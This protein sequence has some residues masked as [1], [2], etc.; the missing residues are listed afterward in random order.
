MFAAQVQA[1]VPANGRSWELATF[2]PPSSS[3]VLGPRPMDGDG[4]RFVYSVIGPHPG[5]SA[6]GVLSFGT[7]DRSPAGWV[8]APLG[9]PYQIE[10]TAVLDLV[11]PIM[12]IAFSDD[13]QASL[14]FSTVPLGPGAPPEGPTTLYRDTAAGS[15]EFI[16]PVGS[17]PPS[18]IYRGFADIAGDGSRV[19][20]ST[21]EH[22]LA[23]DA[24]RTTGNSVYA[25]DGD[26]L[27]LVDVD[28]GGALLST[29][30][31]EVSQANGMSNQGSGVFFTAPASCNGVE[32]V[33]L[34]DLDSETTVQIS[35][36]ECTR[37]DCDATADVAFAGATEDGEFAFL[38]TTQQL[39]DADHDAGR[40]LYRYDVATGKLNL[41][42][43]AP[44]EVS[45]EVVEGALVF[46]S[47]DGGR[48]YFRA[49]GEVI[50]GE[51]TA[52]E[53][54][55]MADGGGVHLVAPASFPIEAEIQLSADG[56]RALFVTK[57]QLLGAD[58]DSS[59]DAYLYDADSETLVRIS[60]GPAGGN[61]ASP[62]SIEAPTPLNRHEYEYGDL[63]QYYAITASGDRAF[64]M[65]D[66][67]LVPEDTNGV[68]D[69][70]EWWN[71]QASLVTPGGQPLKS[72]FGGISRD[73]R[74]LMFATNASLVPAD[75]DG[76]GRDIYLARLDGGFPR[77]AGSLPCDASSC[78]LPV[79]GRITRP[80][81][82]SMAPAR[83]KPGQLRVVEVASKAK[84]GAIAVVVSAP[85]PGSVSGLIWAR[86]KGKKVTIARGSKKAKRSGK[87]NL[88]LRLTSAARRA[89]A[90]GAR[91]WHLTVSQGSSKASQVVKVSLR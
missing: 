28:D 29:C 80:T 66:E 44:S 60:T 18:A 22:L 37:V 16:A 63:R 91:Q 85:S 33:Y 1:A 17:L 42:S 9:F 88:V 72:E 32:K 76:E 81:P 21:K 7:A 58:T 48:V 6:G 26:G 11:A 34:R 59:G 54:L 70:Y 62:A 78:P 15:P 75:V 47:E 68:F 31:S 4:E 24:V 2:E 35:A 56:K 67:S 46:P 19:V 86:E 10:S 73:G 3:R 13:E 27:E 90:V 87:V 50:P 36:S 77:P 79:G 61:G 38:T 45:G 20:F 14:W 74:S 12:P 89:P 55:F 43:G 40:D 64:F 25:W 8:H 69:V 39:T 41:L 57:A 53:K 84:K 51:S 23:G 52:G 5:S 30:G 71:G 49:S 83:H 65:T 82:A